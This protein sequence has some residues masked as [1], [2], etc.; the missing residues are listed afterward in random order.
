MGDTPTNISEYIDTVKK[1][2][3]EYFG[4]YYGTYRGFVV[5]NRDPDFLGRLKLHIPQI[6]AKNI[7]QTWAWPRGQIAGKDFGDFKIPPKDAMVWVTFENGDPSH[8]LW[9]GG[10]WS[11]GNVPKEGKKSPP[12]NRV[13]KTKNWIL[14]MD[15]TEGAEKFK[16]TDIKKGNTF[17]FDTATGNLNLTVKGDESIQTTG[18]ATHNV[19]GNKSEEIDGNHSKQ[20]SGNKT[21]QVNGNSS[22]T[23][24]GNKSIN[25]AGFSLVATQ[26]STMQFGA[27]T[28]TL[29]PN[30]IAFDVGGNTIEINAGGVFIQGRKFLAHNHSGVEPG[31]GSTGGVN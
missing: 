8:P 6:A 1:Y 3:F 31:G 26:A 19:T 18:N 20:I 10:A 25:C 24:T 16:I 13:M 22:E 9:E 15:D 12:D 21:E 30:Q 4:L 29:S 17:E 7:M 14:E 28:I 5:D 23:L 11:K 2:G 27:T